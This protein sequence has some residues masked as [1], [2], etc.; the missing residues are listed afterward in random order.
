MAHSVKT[1]AAVFCAIIDYKIAYEKLAAG[2]IDG[3][4]AWLRYCDEQLATAGFGS[5]S[6]LKAVTQKYTEKLKARRR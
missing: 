1:Q 5:L 4:R 6:E 2:D 3:H